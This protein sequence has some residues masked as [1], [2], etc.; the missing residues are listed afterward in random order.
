MLRVYHGIEASWS[1]GE[2]GRL[3]DGSRTEG[4][5]LSEVELIE[6]E[7]LTTD[8]ISILDRYVFSTPRFRLPESFARVV[9]VLT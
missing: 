7:N 2:G 5:V 9:L 4:T 6:L 8:V 3:E 1:R